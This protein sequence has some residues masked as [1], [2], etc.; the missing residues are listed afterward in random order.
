MSTGGDPAGRPRLADLAETVVV[1]PVADRRAALRG[2]DPASACWG[3]AATAARVVLGRYPVERWAELLES[4][5]LVEAR[6]FDDRRD[7]HWLEGRGVVLE[8]AAA[9]TAAEPAGRQPRDFLIAGEEWLQRDRRSRLWG[10]WLEDSDSW[11][12]ERIPDP[13]RYEGLEPSAGNRFAFLLYRE[14]IR[15]GRLEYVRYLGVEGGAE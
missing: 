6:L 9:G 5:R 2:I 15:A 12:E 13:Q 14:Y 4:P 1:R 10:E 3:F 8:V 11:Y 7:F